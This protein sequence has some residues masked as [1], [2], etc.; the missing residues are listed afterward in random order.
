MPPRVS[1]FLFCRNRAGTIRRSVKSV[2]GQTY[3]DFEYII[4]DGASTDGTLELLQEYDDPRIRL[5]SEQDGGAAE[6]FWLALRR[7]RGEYVCA[8]LSDEELLP[9]AIEEAVAALDATPEAVAVTRDAYLT[10]IDGRALRTVHSQPFDL[11]QYMANRFAPNFSAAMFRMSSLEAAGLRA[12]QW[13]RD[14]GEFELW[15]RLALLG[16]IPYVP[17]VATKYAQ[18]DNQLSRDPANAIRLARGRTRVIDRIAEETGVFDGRPDLLRACHVATVVSFANHLASL[19]ARSE[20]VDLYLSLVNTA[21]R[22]PEPRHPDTPSA[23]YVRVARAQRLE[24]YDRLAL[25]I[26]ETARRLTSVDASVPYEIA[27]THAAADRIDRA[28]ALYETAIELDP[29]CLE[30]HWERGVLFERRGQID[31]AIEAWR[32]SDLTRNAH[33]HSLYLAAILKSPRSTNESLF[34]DHRAW[35]RHHAD[36]AG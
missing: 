28:L 1:V 12:R 5:R 18:H 21:G 34:E 30:A 23:E 31:E 6:A 9:G 14:C 10:D 20:A 2:L 22:L 35:A 27:K 7:C 26:L 16:P 15:C 8:C 32:R 19:G 36:G 25:S 4:Q 24:G 33:R 3:R 29:D 11:V 17:S 13:D